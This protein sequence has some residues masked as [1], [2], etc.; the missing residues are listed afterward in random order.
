MLETIREFA[1]ERLEETDET[2]AVRKRHA[3]HYLEVVR[4]ADE[5]LTGPQQAN[6]FIRLAH[7]QDNTR[8]ALTWAAESQDHELPIALVAA[9]GW[10]WFM[11]GEFEEGSH[12]IDAALATGAGSPS[13]PSDGP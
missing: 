10:F 2:T 6:W 8:A 3:R 12:W 7:E 5:Q 9:A 4:D 1:R 11:R 13:L